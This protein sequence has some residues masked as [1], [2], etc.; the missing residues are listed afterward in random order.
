MIL[1]R[2]NCIENSIGFTRAEA[3][4]SYSIFDRQSISIKLYKIDLTLIKRNINVSNN[5]KLIINVIQ[6]IFIL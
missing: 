3:K 1:L 6:H 4:D 5:N 2:V